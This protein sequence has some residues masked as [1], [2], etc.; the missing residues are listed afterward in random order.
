VISTHI[1]GGDQD[2]AELEWF[3]ALVKRLGVRRYLEIGS[4]NGDSFDAVMRAIGPGGYGL[5]V[6]LPENA[7]ALDNL[8]RTVADLGRDGIEC[9][10][11][12]GNSH[13]SITENRIISRQPFDLVLI[14]ADH[15][16]WGVK[17]DFA[18]YGKFAPVVALHD[19]G[20]PSGHQSDGYTNGVGDFWRELSGPGGQL[21][22]EEFIT[23]GRHMGFGVVYQPVIEA[24]PPVEVRAG[25]APPLYIEIPAWGDYC[26][27]VACRFTVPALLASLAESPFADVTF[28]VHTD[29][30]DAFKAAIGD[31]AKIRF[32]PL[33]AMSPLPASIGGKPPRLPDDWWVAFKRAHKD[34]LAAT[35]RGAIVTLLNADVIPSR[36]C[37]SIVAER[38][39]A[40]AKAVVSVGIRTQIEDND[41]P[42]VGASA[43]ELFQWIWGHRHHIT[44]ECIWGS[45]RSQ[46][47]TILFF[48]DDA[49]GVSMHCFHQTPMF[50]RK[51]RE[52]KFS[53][54]IDDDLLAQ[55]PAHQVAYLSAGEVAFAEISPNW[56]THPFGQPL[57]VQSVL[58]FWKRRRMTALYQR[59]FAQRFRILGQPAATHP[60][61]E[62]IIRELAR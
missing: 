56:K 13:I 19:V 61:A 57:T 5:A 44:E 35:P 15:R 1:R 32:M 27:G 45:G 3:L 51:E 39:A 11:L 53:G 29:Q 49:G 12:F 17:A 47:P 33:M 7:R 38:F 2:A 10:V 26:V 25:T 59:N 6:D 16:Y 62:A 30:R 14:D 58:G 40:G 18:T 20:A 31:R 60:A 8:R 54:T 41:G 42:P 48:P 52:L 37:F 23:P 50:V 28:L 22:T 46:H 21:R 34:A 43:D 55:F 9:E 4:R 36:E 24:P